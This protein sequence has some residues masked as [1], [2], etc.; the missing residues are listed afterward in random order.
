MLV[1]LDET[2]SALMLRRASLS[3]SLARNELAL[4][5]EGARIEDIRRAEAAVTQAQAAA[6]A[7]H[8]DLHRAEQLFAAGSLSQRQL[9]DAEVR[10]ARAAAELESAEQALQT[11]L[12]LSRPEELQAARLRVEQ[13]ETE[14]SLAAMR[15]GRTR[16]VAPSAARVDR[17]LVEPGELA[18]PGAP[19]ARLVTH[20]PLTIAVYL[21]QADLG[22]VAVG[23]RAEVVVDAWP[24][25]RFA[26]RVTRVAEQ[27]EF[28]PRNVQTREDR[29]RLVFEITVELD[30]DRERRLR[31]GMAAEAHF[32]AA[33]AGPRNRATR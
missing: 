21:P 29:A 13:A 8:H 26:G 3:V 14:E 17:L 7:A 11:L 24:D 1:E 9:D 28:T 27:A 22:R 2:E 15:H 30:E 10:H 5:L 4:L 19:V 32:T 20:D 23:D 12:R 6:T 33:G 31:P 16:I 18:R 25:A